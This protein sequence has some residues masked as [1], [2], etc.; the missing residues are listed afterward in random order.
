MIRKCHGHHMKVAKNKIKVEVTF[1]EDEMY[2]IHFLASKYGTE[3]E[4]DRGCLARF[5]HELVMDS[6]RENFKEEI[7]EIRP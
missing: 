1:G 3:F 2:L 4:G 7:N 5:V 6:I